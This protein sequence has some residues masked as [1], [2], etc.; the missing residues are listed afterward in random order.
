MK[1]KIIKLLN[2]LRPV[3]SVDNDLFKMLSDES[4]DKYASP[5]YTAIDDI[6]F[7]TLF[8][9]T[10]DTIYSR[11]TTPGDI[12][13]VDVNG[14]LKVSIWD[15]GYPPEQVSNLLKNKS[16]TIEDLSESILKKVKIIKK[17]E[18]ERQRLLKSK[19]K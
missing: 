11:F 12:E 4:Y 2:I 14:N 9:E 5:L 16:S 18:K 1:E 13:A 17:A 3:I 10:Y 7:M 6:A 15:D 19:E 8:D